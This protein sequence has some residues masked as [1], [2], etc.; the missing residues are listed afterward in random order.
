MKLMNNFRR[1]LNIRLA[2]RASNYN[3]NFFMYIKATVIFYVDGASVVDTFIT[4]SM[5]FT[6]SLFW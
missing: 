2:T 3:M 5:I 1:H 6:T 4:E